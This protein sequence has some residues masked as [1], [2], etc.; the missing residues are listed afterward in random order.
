[1]VSSNLHKL[2]FLNII[3]PPSL[4]EGSFP[5][6]LMI[7]DSCIFA[8]AVLV[9]LRD[10]GSSSALD[11]TLL[12]PGLQ[13]R[14]TRSTQALRGSFR[15]NLRMCRHVEMRQVCEVAVPKGSGSCPGESS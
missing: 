14:M 9:T 6:S 2:C 1:M 7:W 3:V 12:C 11:E 13:P 15:M 5:P 10:N 8:F 4:T